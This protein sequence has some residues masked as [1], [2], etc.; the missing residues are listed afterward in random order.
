[1][2]CR[3]LFHGVELVPEELV[4]G[5]HVDFILLEDGVELVVTEDLALV[6]GVLEAVTLDVVPELLDYLGTG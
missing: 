3:L 4:H 5:E 2:S 6:A 1:M